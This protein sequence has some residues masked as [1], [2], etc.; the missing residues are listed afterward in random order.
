MTSIIDNNGVYTITD[1]ASL[2]GMLPAPSSKL[3]TGIGN[4]ATL[5]L[6]EQGMLK[7]GQS[8]Y[9]SEVFYSYQPVTPIGNFVKIVMPSTLY[10][11]AYF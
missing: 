3:G 7:P 4:T 10:E 6:A 1:Q 11:A 8:I 2:G 9:V 5:S